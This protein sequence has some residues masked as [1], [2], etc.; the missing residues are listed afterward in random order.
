MI[1]KVK[2]NISIPGAESPVP[3]IDIFIRTAGP[4]GVETGT[5]LKQ[6]TNGTSYGSH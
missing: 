2:T 6:A 1:F 3:G 5:G 4:I